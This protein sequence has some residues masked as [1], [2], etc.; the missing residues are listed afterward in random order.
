MQRWRDLVRCRVI[1]LQELLK[2]QL[3]KRV[4]WRVIIRLQLCGN[5]LSY[6]GY[7]HLCRLRL[8]LICFQLVILLRFYP[9]ISLLG[10]LGCSRGR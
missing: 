8:R 5:F 7:R 9:L 2:R 6:R 3:L 10:R 4:N 1:A